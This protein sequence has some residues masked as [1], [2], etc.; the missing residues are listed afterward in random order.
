VRH[1][2]N[3]TANPKLALPRGSVRR[4]DWSVRGRERWWI[5]LG[6]K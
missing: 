6:R 4:L 2:G 5:I 3:V 1:Q